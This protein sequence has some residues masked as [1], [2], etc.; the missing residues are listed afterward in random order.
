[1]IRVKKPLDGSNRFECAGCVPCFA[2]SLF[3]TIL[4]ILSKCSALLSVPWSKVAVGRRYKV[5]LSIGS[6]SRLGASKSRH[7]CFHLGTRLRRFLEPLGHL[8]GA[9]CRWSPRRAA[10][11][12]GLRV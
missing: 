1:M 11:P 12:I 6:H 8:Q 3:Q 5:V 10:A 9:G 2:P 7:R 4:L